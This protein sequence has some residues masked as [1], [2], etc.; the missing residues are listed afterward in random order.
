MSITDLTADML[1][2]IR[3]ASRAHKEAVEIKRSK[4]LSA[5]CE[6]LKKEGFI[7]NFKEIEDKKQGLIKI[8]LKYNKD[9]S[10]A[11]VGLKSISTAGLRR[12]EGYEDFRKI[13]GGVGIAIVSTSKGIMT[14][15]EA[16]AK[17]IGGEIICY[18]W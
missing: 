3:N 18:A 8:Y 13:L 14:T 17:K 12:Y 9:N 16:R 11:I 4:L 1:T 2:M 15:K 5:I 10:S 7:A 6:I